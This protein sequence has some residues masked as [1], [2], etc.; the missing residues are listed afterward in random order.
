MK[1]A[2][3]ALLFCALA[4]AAAAQTA[5]PTATA[6]KA[7]TK[8][9]GILGNRNT[10]QPIDIA[11]DKSSADLNTKTVNWTGN[12]VVTQGDIKMHADAIKVSSDNGKASS[13]Q[14]SGHVVVDSP[15]TG[16]VTGDTGVYDVG[17][18]SVLMTGKVVLTH[19]KDVMRG[20]R[21]SV[22]LDTGQAVLGAAGPVTGTVAPGTQNGRVQGIFTPSGGN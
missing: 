2:A 18:H 5:T 22:N 17:A 12:V 1:R 13:I 10:N 7:A 15:A 8:T 21:L 14:A 6:P 19:G 9:G 4:G 3:L 20:T 16:T 11:A